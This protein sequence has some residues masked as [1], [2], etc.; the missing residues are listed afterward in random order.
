MKIKE[1]KTTRTK[2]HKELVD[3]LSKKRL[4][5][6]KIQAKIL[7]GKEK[8]TKAVKHARKEIAQLLTLIQE[9]EMIPAGEEKITKDKEVTKQK[10]QKEGKTK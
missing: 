3:L 10:S 5:L 2:D 4:D 8:N 7:S 9:K 6:A 1:L